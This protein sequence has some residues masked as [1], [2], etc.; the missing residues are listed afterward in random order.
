M[1]ITK[2]LLLTV[3]AIS[4]AGCD[5]PFGPGGGDDDEKIDATLYELRLTTNLD[6]AKGGI[7]AE[8]AHE[9]DPEDVQALLDAGATQADIDKAGTCV[10]GV[11]YFFD[12]DP[13]NLYE[14]FLVGYEFLGWFDG[15]EFL[16]YLDVDYDGTPNYI[17]NMPGKNTNLEARF[18]L[19]Q[20][21]ILYMDEGTQ[22]VDPKGNPT[23]WNIEDGE[24]ELKHLDRESEGLKFDGWTFAMGGDTRYD[25][26]VTKLNEEFLIK[27]NVAKQSMEGRESMTFSLHENY[28]EIERNVQLTFDTKIIECVRVEITPPGETT[29][30][31]DEEGSI[32]LKSG[33]IETTV[34]HNSVVVVYPALTYDAELA[35]YEIDGIYFGNYKISEQVSG[36]GYKITAS[37]DA[38]VELRAKLL[39]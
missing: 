30:T 21:D 16:G 34:K 5:L 26:Y 28:S 38:T 24:V 8:L 37:Q 33:N 12:Q 2:V 19:M 13:I 27:S 23:R 14:P 32:W 1:K 39:A 3:A 17:W 11:Y 35:G 6:K 36:G 10:D 7:T 15:N 9:R 31:L 18:K 29:Y 20:F 25:G 4:L 22:T